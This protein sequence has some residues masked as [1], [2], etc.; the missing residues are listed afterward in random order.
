MLVA[1]VG[2]AA[3]LLAGVLT[4]GAQVIDDSGT[5]SP[6]VSCSAAVERVV[7]LMEEHP[8]VA[9][10]YADE[11]EYLPDV[12]S[13]EEVE[14]CGDPQH[15]LEEL[16]DAEGQEVGEGERGGHDKGSTTGAGGG[17]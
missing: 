16:G 15:L 2:A 11:A 17:S 1:N 14:A 8:E 4:A 13:E 6:A 7:D 9:D 10:I 12:F 3:T 5:G